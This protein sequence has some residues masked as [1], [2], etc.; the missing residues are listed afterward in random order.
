MSTNPVI[1]LV[2][3]QPDWPSFAGAP[4]QAIRKIVLGRTPGE[5]GKDKKPLSILALPADFG[6]LF[7]HLTHLYLWGIQALS[8][9][10][11]LPPKLECLDVRDCPDVSA[12]TSLPATLDTLVLERCPQLSRLPELTDRTFPKLRDLSLKSC[13]AI[14]ESWV[15]E[16]L[17]AS[18]ELSLFDA[19]DCPQ[20]TH[21]TRWPATLDRIDLNQCAALQ[22]LPDEWP[23]RL[24]RLGLRGS[25]ALGQL[26][27][28]YNDWTRQRMDE[29]LDYVDLAGTRSLRSLPTHWGQPRFK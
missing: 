11:E 3:Q 23:A 12:I 28:F 4:G 29:K 8:A 7:P 21:I 22:A 25:S 1:N 17:I 15:N 13:A 19:S 18:P 2:A 9:L 24:R 14:P 27:D 20:L 10:P 16:V 5:S 26:P 6:T